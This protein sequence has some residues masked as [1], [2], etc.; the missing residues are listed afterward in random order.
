MLQSMKKRITTGFLVLTGLVFCGC[1][2]D[3]RQYELDSKSFDSKTLQRI[4]SDTGIVLPVG[5]RGLNFYYT[6]PI[7][8]AYIAKIEIP[9]SS[10]DDLIKKLSAIKNDD[11]LHVFTT[12]GTK[13]H[14]WIPK[15]T[16]PVMDR[17]RQVG[18]GNYLHVILTEEDG[19]VILYIE[20][21]VG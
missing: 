4:Q 14:W 7:D 19:R 16:K 10:K 17:Q 8:P 3:L 5:A 20:W 21:S 12:L 15:G 11:N 9:R 18:T 13:V 6:P 1:D 2:R